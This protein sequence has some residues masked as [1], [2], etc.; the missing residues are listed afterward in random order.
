MFEDI[1]KNI[2]VIYTTHSPHLVDINKLHRVLAV[3]RDD[4]EN[5]RS[6]TTV[7]DAA[8]LSN[9]SPDT[10]SPLQSIMGNPVGNQEFSTDKFNI[11]VN[12]VGILPA[13]GGC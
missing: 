5:Q 4:I 1:K 9:A 8:R 2:Q 3:Q 12:D 10:L 7:L 13:Y 11:I 6:A